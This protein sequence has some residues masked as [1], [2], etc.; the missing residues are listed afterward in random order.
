MKV[1]HNRLLVKIKIWQKP[2][3]I[4]WGIKQMPR[5]LSLSKY[6]A[7]NFLKNC[8][9]KMSYRLI[10]HQIMC[11]SSQLTLAWKKKIDSIKCLIWSWKAR[12]SSAR[13]RHECHRFRHSNKTY[14]QIMTALKHPSKRTW[15]IQADYLKKNPNVTV[16]PLKMTTA[17]F[18][19]ITGTRYQLL[20]QLTNR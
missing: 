16:S 4:P 8:M 6:Q 9:K 5:E 14:C 11:T 20:I 3:I 12:F 18:C 17:L 10:Q 15:S 13:P 19:E 7:H 2:C 1:W